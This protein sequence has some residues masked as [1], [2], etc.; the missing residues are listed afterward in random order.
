MAGES[1]ARSTPT[2]LRRRIH[3]LERAASRSFTT[4]ESSTR[5]GDDDEEE[6]DDGELISPPTSFEAVYEEGELEEEDDDDEEHTS[7]VRGE[8]PHEEEEEDDDGPPAS[9][10]W[11]KPSLSVL[12]A[13]APP[14]GNWLTGGDHLKDFCCSY[15]LYFIST[16]SSRCPGACTTRP[17]RAAHPPPPWPPPHPHR[18]P[19]QILTP[20]LELS[21]SSLPPRAPPR[22]PPPPLPRLLLHLQYR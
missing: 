3:L 14:I 12:I 5:N 21:C 22:R 18:R 20:H 15:C 1:S 9:R 11:Y 4:A 2:P 13:L 6:E 8:A 16:S 17:V 7:T 10:P 19:C